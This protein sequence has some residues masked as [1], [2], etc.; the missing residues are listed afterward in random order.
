MSQTKGNNILNNIFIH[1]FMDDATLFNMIDTEESISKL[2]CLLQVLYERIEKN[3]SKKHNFSVA[4]ILESE[5]SYDMKKTALDFALHIQADLGEFIYCLRLFNEKLSMIDL[6]SKWED[7][8]MDSSEILCLAAVII[9]VNIQH[10]ED[11]FKYVD[12]LKLKIFLLKICALKM[13]KDFPLDKSSLFFKYFMYISSR[14]PKF[15]D[16]TLQYFVE[17]ENFD[18]LCLLFDKT[19]RYL[20]TC[21]YFKQ[22]NF[23]TYI[24]IHIVS[25]DTV[26][27][28]QVQ[29][30]LWRTID[31]YKTNCMLL[32]DVLQTGTF[33]DWDFFFI[34]LEMSK[35]KQLHLIQPT[36]KLLPSITELHMSWRSCLYRELLNH[37]QLIVVYNIV[38]HILKLKFSCD[39]IH[40]KILF[41][42]LL[43]LNKFEYSN[44]SKDVFCQLRI[45]CD[46]LTEDCYLIFFEEF[47]RID[48][49]PAAAWCVLTSSSTILGKIPH[50]LI[51]KML[52][53]L[54]KLPHTYIKQSCIIFF[55]EKFLNNS[56][57]LFE[58][59]MLVG[60]FL[61]STHRKVD[62]EVFYRI[63]EQRKS[64]I[65]KY[66]EVL[67]KSLIISLA[68]MDSECLVFSLE[69]MRKLNMEIK[70]DLAIPYSGLGDIILFYYP[71]LIKPS[72]LENYLVERFQNVDG[73]DDQFLFKL[74]ELLFDKDLN[75]ILS[76]EKSL[77]LWNS[78]GTDETKRFFASYLLLLTVGPN[79]ID[80]VIMEQAEIYLK[81]SKYDFGASCMKRWRKCVEK[82]QDEQQMSEMLKT[83]LDLLDSDDEKKLEI[84]VSN[85]D[86]V[87]KY[88]TLWKDKVIQILDL[89]LR[90]LCTL[91]NNLMREYS[92]MFFHSIFQA[93]L[94][95]IAAFAECWEKWYSELFHCYFFDCDYLLKIMLEGCRNII[96][97]EAPFVQTL[98]PFILGA[99][100][101]GTV[102]QKNQ[103]VEYGICQEIHDNIDLPFIQ[104]PNII[105]SESKMLSVECLYLLAKNKN[106]KHFPSA[107]SLM[108]MLLERYMENYNKRYFPESKI[109]LDKLRIVQAMLIIVNFIDRSKDQLVQ[110]ILKSFCEESHQPSVKQL[111]Q[112]LLIILV[113]E[114]PDYLKLMI[115]KVETENFSHPSTV[116]TLIPVMYHLVTSLGDKVYW[117]EFTDALIPLMMGANFK[118]RVYSQV[119]LRNILQKAKEAQLLE[120]TDKYSFLEKSIS[121]VLDATGNSV[122]ETLKHDIVFIENFDPAL[123]FS[124]ETIFVTLPK[125]L[126]VP[127]S[128][129]ENVLE[130]RFSEK[131]DI[132]IEAV[133]K[134]PNIPHPKIVDHKNEDDLV[135]VNVQKKIIPWKQDLE[136]K[137]DNDC[138][139]SLICVASLV[140]KS[141]NIG[142]LSRTCEIFN[143]QQLVLHNIKIKDDKE[144][145]NLSMSSENWVDFMEVKRDDLS[146]FLTTLRQ[147]GYS[148][149]GLEQTSESVKLD[150]FKF[151]KKTVI[152]LGNEKGGIPAPLLPLLDTCV[153]IPQFGQTRSL[154]VHVAGATFIWEY[155]KQH[156]L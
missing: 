122:S 71:A 115:K 128:E 85:L 74:L 58:N 105:T 136:E 154:N 12:K 149:V 87:V 140:E 19:L 138:L 101:K 62:K 130:H 155:V 50:H 107:D 78:A 53:C 103:R 36:L 6:E 3:L 95:S 51:T 111:L 129:W 151:E 48:W 43:A 21:E 26:R 72:D 4:K 81:H 89:C 66:E 139:N 84:V 99:L 20:V 147:Q 27:K 113:T 102:I 1:Q 15:I 18:F 120:F 125:M 7:I 34:L 108:K 91:P 70:K 65:K 152:L 92:A 124:V 82:V 57:N 132:K 96:L 5:C 83:F 69:L 93:D 44:L 76:S 46:E 63:I 141:S 55:I 90:K 52:L 73:S 153:E 47:L 9:D 61:F 10:E 118:L 67:E 150:K 134:L 45:F 49:N 135:C 56:T 116:V 35:E 98:V 31:Y 75:N 77:A 146:N 110:F 112:W 133:N 30:I 88:A 24:K 16:E 100:T 144:F 143:V 32:P 117:N 37:S 59:L 23:W 123:H 127:P 42:C 11:I 131:F 25:D 121:A 104:N 106:T 38:K 148:I 80:S 8:I 13:S 79:T 40:R 94:F 97:Q 145:K 29:Y 17:Q 126:D 14:D 137:I 156:M 33:Q 22:D 86:L 28:K 119:I 114:T 142:G 39:E 41:D 109:H 64:E 60:K 54:K 2:S 68:E